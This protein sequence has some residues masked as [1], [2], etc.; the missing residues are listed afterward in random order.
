MVERGLVILR[1]VTQALARGG[2]LDNEWMDGGTTLTEKG[3]RAPAG[4][5]GGWIESAR[6]RMVRW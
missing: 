2:R 6:Q 1:M 5:L 3:T 4:Q